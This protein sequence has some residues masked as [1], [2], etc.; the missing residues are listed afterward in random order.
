MFYK[1]KKTKVGLIVTMSLDTTWPD[2]IVNKVKSYLPLAKEVIEKT[3]SVVYGFDDIARTPEEMR[4]QAEKLRR[5]NINVLVIYVGTWTYSSTA[6][7]AA[8]KADVPVI[9]WANDSL[10]TFGIVGG[11]ISRGALDEVGVTNYLVYGKFDDERVLQELGTTING[12]AGA[13]KLRGMIYGEGGSRCMG[14][15][16]ARIDPSEWMS[17]FGVDVDG[18]EQ[19]KVLEKAENISDEEAIKFLDWM[20]L[21]FGGVEAKE[22][23][24]LA[25]IKLYMALREII[26][27]KNYDFI[28]VKCLPELPSCH[29]TFCIAHTLLNDSANDG[30]GDKKSFVVACEADSNGALTMQ[31][32]N[33][34]TG[35][36]TMFTDV[37]YFDYKENVI[38][39]CNCGAQPTDFAKSRKDVVWVHEGLGEFD[40]KMGGCCPRYIGGPGRVTLARLSRIK[41][42]YVM[43]ITT[44]NALETP[45]EKINETNSQQPHIFVKLD[46]NPE[47]FIKNLR[48]NH[49]HVVKGDYE[50]ELIITCEVAGIRP[51]VLQ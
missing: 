48:S 24:M 9:V 2:S 12:I 35:D 10:E 16:T 49:V 1:D 46:C 4:D 15:Y 38:R 21:E 25:Q 28:S 34:I 11:S 26:K 42:E 36:T 23:V 22:K 14:M 7:M 32:L 17:K 29:T 39:M 20:K 50:K 31:I 43:L 27:E 18:F 19:V 37:L 3:G 33:N 44:G 5:E 8:M 41:G 30:F 47:N 6:V 45:L 51:I 40:W 13:T